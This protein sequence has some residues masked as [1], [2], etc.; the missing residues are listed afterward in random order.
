MVAG[1]IAG[2]HADAVDRRLRGGAGGQD[3]VANFLVGLTSITCI[4]VL[5]AA[6]R[7][8]AG[9]C[10]AARLRAMR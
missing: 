5:L 4:A 9:A 7:A 1:S 2:A 6:G 8:G 3:D 10:G